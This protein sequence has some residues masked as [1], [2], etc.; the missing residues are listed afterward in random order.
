MTK[1]PEIENIEERKLVRSLHK[2]AHCRRTEDGGFHIS[3]KGKDGKEISL[4]HSAETRTE[5]WGNAAK[6]IDKEISE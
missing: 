6:K 3:Y 4:G 5:A 1:Q 2:T